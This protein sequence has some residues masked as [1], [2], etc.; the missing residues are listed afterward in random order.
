MQ[1]FEG[2][3]KSE[4][5]LEVL[6]MEIRN[7]NSSIIDISALEN[8]LDDENEDILGNKIEKKGKKNK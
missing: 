6:N 5:N 2:N 8:L 1:D 3:L 4:Q 7:D